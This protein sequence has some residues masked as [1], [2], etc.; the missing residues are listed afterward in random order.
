[1]S[2][3]VFI[4]INNKSRLKKVQLSRLMVCRVVVH[5]PVRTSRVGL[6]SQSQNCR[7]QTG[8]DD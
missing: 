2:K 3:V 6:L 4:K 8:S 7:R 1:M 5:S